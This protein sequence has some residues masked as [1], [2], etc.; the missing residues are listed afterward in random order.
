MKTYKK[1]AQVGW[2]SG[3]GEKQ[4]SNRSERSFIKKELSNKIMVS[5]DEER[6]QIR[7]EVLC[8]EYD[9]ETFNKLT[10]ERPD[11][12]R[13]IEPFCKKSKKTTSRK[14]LMGKIS[15]LQSQLD[16]LPL[17]GYRSGWLK[18]YYNESILKIKEALDSFKK[19]SK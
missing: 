16:R 14:S 12:I 19:E 13:A 10:K 1:R 4:S 9:R 11:L 3:K 2:N 17:D 6:V 5:S 8:D 18:N 15:Y 7:S